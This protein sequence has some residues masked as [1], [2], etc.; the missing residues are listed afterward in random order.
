MKRTHPRLARR[1]LVVP[2]LLALALTACSGEKPEAMLA[3]ARDYLAKD[4][5][6]AAVI[7]VKNALQENPD[8]AEARYILAVALLR[9]GDAVGAETELRK[10]MALKYPEEKTVPSLAQALLAQGQYKKLIDE[11]AD[12]DLSQPAAK[13][14]LL[15]AVATAYIVTRNEDKAKST[16]DAALKADPSYVPA[17][18]LVVRRQAG[19]GDLDGAI[20]AI[21]AILAKT[22]KSYD[23]QKLKGDLLLAK[24]NPDAALVAFR[25][26]V[27]TKT[28]FLAARLA[29]LGILMSQGKLDE[30]TKELDVALKQAPNS[31]SVHYF[32]VQ[33]A[34]QKKDYKKAKDLVQRLLKATPESPQALML[35]G[36]IELQIGTALQA[37]AYLTKTLQ[38]APQAKLARRLLVSAYLRSGQLDKAV[39]TLQPLLKDADTDPAISALAGEAFLQSGDIKKAE[40]YFAKASRQD[41]K[42]ARNRTALALTHVAGGNASGMEELQAIAESESSTMADMALISVSLRRGEFDKALKAIDGLEKKQPGKP[43]APNL[44]GRTLLAK[45][46]IAGARKAFEQA[47][48]LDPGFIPAIASLAALDV[49]DKNPERA[50]KRFE[51]VLAKTPNQPQALL[52]LAELRARE[53]GKKEEVIE[54]ITKAITS[55]PTETTPRLL[56]VDLYLRSKEAKLALAAAQSAAAAIPDSAEIIDAL[57]RA[58]LATGDTNQALSTFNKVVALQ[59]S[60]PIPFMRLAD[61]NMVAK[62]KNGAA[63]S[64]RRALEVKPDYLDA[65]LG[66]IRLAIDAKNYSEATAIA[67]SVQKQRP[68]ESIG[69]QFEGDI[70]AAQKKFD[71]AADIFRTGLK[72]GAFP[73]VAIKLHAV[74]K[75]SGKGGEADKL[76]SS[77]LIDHPKEPSMRMYLA[78]EALATKDYVNAEKLYLSVVQIQPNNAIAYNNLAWVTS[79]LKKDGAIAYAEKALAM[80]PNQP[81]YMDT[82]AMLLLDKNDLAKALQWQTK[83]V[84]LSPANPLYKLNLAR[85]HVKSGNKD[86]ARK[87]LDELAKLG[88]KFTGQAQVTELLKSL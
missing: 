73:D 61:A 22:P 35:A 68:K 47:V 42:N 20:V 79:E 76:A 33:L 28:D 36:A 23:A 87:E 52:A 17:Q 65:Q 37:E 75:G 63:Q 29:M 7:Q 55:N 51:D 5:L 12:K 83:A 32:E 18:L 34:Y 59:P 1:G 74:L 77:W 78:Q 16:L 10:A 24:K 2:L 21:D 84:G 19:G 85:I 69:Y 3:S 26:A 4:D 14:E 81:A 40:E 6:K 38:S 56:L 57:G 45:K 80:V 86:L 53:G 9:S 41:P 15:T 13:A 88:D 70:A 54:L 71:L 62:D 27:D 66:L 58:Q 82:L 11:M 60:S 39:A 8:L 48:S 72:Q 64:L 31:A 46:D 25:S 49:A 30:A 50:R 44:R 67:R 43:I